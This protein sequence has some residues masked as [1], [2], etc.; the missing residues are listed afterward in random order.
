MVDATPDY[1]FTAG[2]ISKVLNN[3]QR[4]F[5]IAEFAGVRHRPSVEHQ[6]TDE[7]NAV[8]D[9]NCETAVWRDKPAG[10]GNFQFNGNGA[11]GVTYELDA[12]TDLMPPV[13]WMFVTNAVAG[14]NGLFQ[15]ACRAN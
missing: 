4:K 13:L 9:R 7:R 3:L 1:C 10:D 5:L 8:S 15:F 12:A 14:Q 2:R 6:W 11:A